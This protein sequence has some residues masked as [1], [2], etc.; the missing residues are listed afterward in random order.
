MA[1]KSSKVFEFKRML[2]QY[3]YSL[4][5]LQDLKEINREVTSDF[6]SALAAEKRN[7]LFESQKV[8]QAAEEAEVEEIIP[9][10]RDP[11]F[12]KL[13]RKIVVQCH[14]DKFTDDL[15]DLQKAFKK[16]MYDRAVKAN[17]SYNW[18]ELIT[19]AIKLEIDLP[20]EY[21]EYVDNL[22]SDA[23]KVQEEI[24]AIQ[25]SIAWTWYH[26]TDEQ[27]PAIMAQYIKHMEKMVFGE[28]RPVYKVLGVG[29]PRTGTGYTT[30]LLQSWGLKVCHEAFDEDGIVAWQLAVKEGP[31]VFIKDN[32][33]ADYQHKIYC[34]RNPRESLPSIVYTENTI[35]HSFN[36]RASKCGRALI[37]NP[38]ENAIKLLLAWDDKIINDIQPDIIYRIEHDSQMLYDTLKSRGLE[39][40]EYTPLEEKVNQ[41][42]HLSFDQMM[43]EFPGISQSVLKGI[44]EYCER[45]GYEKLF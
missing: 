5:D 45:Y 15:T 9:E 38:L 26:A 1:G 41:R 18:A 29:H 33:D 30:K 42:V 39:L 23:E 13:F 10:E 20:E 11:Q 24:D 37:G 12:K 44:N 25:G 8:A 22:K 7:D 17:D 14:P 35:D 31:W 40:N 32:I 34:V 4:E 3:E 27:K 43:E 21:Y 16:D 19:V 28:R 6:S 36:Y 2:R